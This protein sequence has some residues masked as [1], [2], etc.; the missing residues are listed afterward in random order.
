MVKPIVAMAATPDGQGYWL[1][2]SDGGVFAY[3]D[4]NFYGSTGAI[5]LNEPIVGMAATPDGR[6]YW[7]VASDGG[8]FTFGDAAFYGSTGAIH[9]NEPIVGMA[10]TP[11]GQGYWL[12]ASDG[13]IFT[14]GDAAFYGSTGAIHLN[15]PIV[16]MAPTPDGQGYWLVASDGGI[17]T[18]GDATFDGSLGA[19]SASVLGIVD[20]PP[21]RRL[22]L[23]DLQTARRRRSPPRRLPECEP[24]PTRRPCRSP[25]RMPLQGSD[26]QPTAVHAHRDGGHR[27]QQP[28]FQRNGPGLGRLATPPTRPSC[29]TGS[30]A[31]VFSDTLIGT[32]QASGAANVTGLV[33]NSELVG[34]MSGLNSDDIGD[35][36]P[37]DSDIGGT[38]SS[39]QT[40]IPDTTDSG[41]Q[42]Q[43]AATYVENGNQL[44][45]VNEFAPVRERVFD[46]FTGHSGIAVLRRV[47]RWH[48]DLQLR[49]SCTDRP[50]HS[51]GQCDHAERRLH[52]H[53]RDRRATRPRVPST[54]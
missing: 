10:P 17:F 46:R 36:I 42:W 1:V 32:A 20:Q 52:L 34:G 5:H 30:E 33:H 31:F 50:V 35:M 21:D 12:V 26:C 15:E 2:G 51:V 27:A 47:D 45:F 22:H 18:Y 53:L 16:G 24:V 44:V 23:G 13:G 6:G 37:L 4:A 40:L 48:A 7:L 19:A 54:A 9:L 25:H 11:D 8:I 3:G 39:P 49:H 41:D 43:V 28:H 14:F 38:V 29:P